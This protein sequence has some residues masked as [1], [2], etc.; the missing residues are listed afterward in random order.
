MRSVEAIRDAVGTA[1]RAG[2]SIGLVPTMGA[3]HSGHQSL[4]EAARAECGFVVVSIFVNPLQF[5]PGE[6]Y[7]RY[8]RALSADLELCSRAGAD[9]VFAPGEDDMYPSEQLSFTEITK[10]GDHLCG[11]F[12]PGHF[13]GVATVV[14]KLLNMVQPDRAY[15]GEKDIQQLAV[16]RRM[17]RDFALPVDIAGIPTV[18]EADG[19]ALSSR[20]Q[21]LTAQ[22]RQSAAV[23]YRALQ[24]AKEA[25]ASGE[26]DA[27]VIKRMAL[28]V[29]DGEP[30][31]KV[32]YFELVDGDMQPVD[33][34]RAGVRAACAVWFGSTRL[35]DNMSL[36]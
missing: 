7:G 18:R 24:K 17:V 35:I 26:R 19:L 13:R 15:F 20:N 12:R 27:D 4:V 5:G 10:V 22:Q 31:G 2:L 29:L 28:A 21:Y 6:D 1:R 32:Q 11:A 8:P 23:V 3:L 9:L 36:V 16:I 25:A 33:H 34:V 14:L 30:G